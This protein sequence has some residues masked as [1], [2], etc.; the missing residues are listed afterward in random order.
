MIYAGIDPSLESTAMF[1]YD[2]ETS[3]YGYYSFFVTPEGKLQ[4]KKQQAIDKLKECGVD[5]N[6]IANYVDRRKVKQAKIQNDNNIKQQASAVYDAVKDILDNGDDIESLVSLLEDAH[7][8]DLIVYKLMAENDLNR[9]VTMKIVASMVK[10]TIISF[11]TKYSCIDTIISIEAPA[12]VASGSSSV[13]LIAGCAFIRD[14]PNVL[15]DCGIDVNNTY[16]LPPTSVKKEATGRGTATKEEMC[17][18]FAKKGPNDA[19]RELV[20]RTSNIKDYKPMDDIVDAYFMTYFIIG[21]E[22][23]KIIN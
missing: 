11:C 9:F 6:V 1:L 15:K 10:D 3:Q 20:A 18:A 19:F 17:E 7:K 12:Y 13:D 21:N 8:D 22:L 16:M 14:I 2:S 4:R 23:S 5:V